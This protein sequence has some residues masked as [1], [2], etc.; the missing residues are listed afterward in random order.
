MAFFGIFKRKKEE[1]KNLFTSIISSLAGGI[2]FFFLFF[3][4]FRGALSNF[5]FVSFFLLLPYPRMTLYNNYYYF[6]KILVYSL[7]IE[8][9]CLLFTYLTYSITYLF[10]IL[11]L[12]V[13]RSGSSFLGG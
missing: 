6:F 10:S 9:T 4:F 7:I 8:S 13:L 2:F 5:H 12:L 3:P 1:K 11:C